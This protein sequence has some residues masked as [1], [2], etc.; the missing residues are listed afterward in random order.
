MLY[1]TGCEYAVRALVHLAHQ[2]H[3][4]RTPL[5]DVAKGESLPAPFLGKIMKDLVRGGLLVSARGPTGGYALARPAEEITLLEIKELLD[6]PRDLTRCAVG[7][8]PCSDETPCPLHDIWSP[9]RSQIKR[10][11]ETT[12]LAQVADGVTRKRQ[13]LKQS[14]IT[15]K[16]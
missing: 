3:G 11:L 13:L 12:T 15:L 16:T 8:D 7:L 10:Y 1:S 2:P 4:E 9:L 6:G 14:L 5:T